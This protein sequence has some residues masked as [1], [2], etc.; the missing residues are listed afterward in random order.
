MLGE[1]KLLFPFSFFFLTKIIFKNSS[2]E[3]VTEY[4]EEVYLPDDCFMLIKLDMNRIRLLKLEVDATSI[5]W[6]WVHIVM[7]ENYLI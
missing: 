7:L 6:R 3:K 5:R 4:F 2:H 1:V